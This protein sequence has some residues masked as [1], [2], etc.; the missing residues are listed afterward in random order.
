M[1]HSRLSIHVINFDYFLYTLCLHQTLHRVTC[2][3]ALRFEVCITYGMF[4]V[5]YMRNVFCLTICEMFIVYCMWN[6]YCLL[7]AEYF[8]YCTCVSLVCVILNVSYAIL[9]NFTFKSFLFIIFHI[10]RFLLLFILLL[11]LLFYSIY[12]L[13]LCFCYVYH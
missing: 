12:I 13:Y 2:P 10:I 4:I 11:L 7:Y 8:L 9:R 3:F 5:Y 1:S 6:V